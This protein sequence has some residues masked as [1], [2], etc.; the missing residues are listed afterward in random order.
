ML[1]L[2]VGLTSLRLDSPYI[3]TS[4]RRAKPFSGFF[5]YFLKHPNNIVAKNW[6][7]DDTARHFHKKTAQRKPCAGTPVGPATTAAVTRLR[8]MD[9]ADDWASNC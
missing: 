1:I 4:N 3:H 9:K 2:L 5:G 8:H 6:R 7:V